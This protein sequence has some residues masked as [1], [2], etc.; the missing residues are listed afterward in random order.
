MAAPT[1]YY[2]DPSINANSGSGTSGSPY[3]D[4]QYALNTIT[5]DSTNGDII[6]IKAGTSEILTAGLALTTYG[7]PTAAAPLIFRGYTSTAADG[8]IGTIDGAG[9]FGV[10]ASTVLV[11]IHAR[12]MRFTNSGAT[13]LMRTNGDSYFENCRFDNTTASPV[14]FGGAVL[15]HRCRCDNYGTAARFSGSSDV[16]ACV[17][18]PT[19]RTPTAAVQF[20]SGMVAFV[21]N[22][23]RVTGASNGISYVTNNQTIR[24]NAIAWVS[25]S[26]TGTGAGI[27][28]GGVSLR[29]IAVVNN[30][31]EGFAGTGGTGIKDSNAT[32]RPVYSAFGFNKVY[33]C[34]T[35]FDV[36]GDK[37][38]DLGSDATLGASALTSASGGDFTPS[39]AIDDEGYPASYSTF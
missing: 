33:N 21:G 2:V 36:T 28:P 12:D 20:D 4:L 26:G 14:R 24:N 25:G 10:F 38:A 35:A 8:G 5:R 9:S 34:T 29:G 27:L 1:A 11:G 18:D 15:L 22:R 17:F 23:I 30:Y 39:S 37:R 31:V 3:G 16:F 6:H 32:T 13:D 19:S 7:T